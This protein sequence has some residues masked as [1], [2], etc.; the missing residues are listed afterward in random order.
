MIYALVDCNSFFASCERVFRPD[1]WD[2]PVAVMSNN[3]GCIIAR[4]P[5]VKALG[6]KMGA[7]V[8]KVRDTLK[9]HNVALFS[10]NFRLYGELS[11]R[12]MSVLQKFSKD[13]D[14]YSIDEAFLSLDDSVDTEALGAELK[15]TVQ[16]WTGIP[17]GVGFGK[18]KTLAKLS[19]YLAKRSG[20]GVFDIHLFDE[21]K[22]MATVPVGEIWG[23]GRRYAKTLKRHNIRTV[24]QYKEASRWWIQKRLHLPGVRTQ[25]ELQGVCCDE[26]G[27]LESP[28]QSI[29][30]SRTF[31]KRL[32][33]KEDIKGAVAV[34]LVT[35]AEKL[36]RHNLHTEEMVVFISESRFKQGYYSRS[37][38]IRLTEPTSSTTTLLS[39]AVKAVDQL[40]LPCR[41]YARSGV[42]FSVL[43]PDSNLQRSFLMPHSDDGAKDKRC[44]A[45]MD[46]INKQWGKETIQPAIVS[47]EDKPWRMNQVFRS[48]RYLSSWLELP[49]V[50][51]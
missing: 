49:V 41:E 15:E 3:D 19:S 50:K 30:S 42:F 32:Y 9:A 5:E 31:G 6:V 18:T 26:S 8:F 22:V 29:L 40:Y 21:D 13:V 11:D 39:H 34:N 25:L 2:R 45:A 17:V 14:I 36:R 48:P 23:V 24:L 27:E 10:A 1:L 20:R 44:M 37:V 12:V 7:P 43:T 16:K 33:Q 46:A 28:R 38:T 35:A 47:W 4:T 51:L